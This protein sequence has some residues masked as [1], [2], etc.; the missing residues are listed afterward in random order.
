MKLNIPISERDKIEEAL[1]KVNGK[2]KVFTLDFPGIVNVVNRTDRIFSKFDATAKE[3]TGATVEYRP[4]GPRA[5][6]Y[7]YRARS[8]AI[9]LKLRSGDWHLVS[10]IEEH[11]HPGQGERFKIRVKPAAKTAMMARMAQLVDVFPQE[12]SSPE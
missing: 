4:R 7:G 11:V 1:A 5:K 9:V 8:T 2:A 3:T 6:S 10:A 12:R